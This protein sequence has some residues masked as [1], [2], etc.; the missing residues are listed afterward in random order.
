MGRVQVLELVGLFLLK[1][2]HYFVETMSA[3]VE[4]ALVET[5]K[6]VGED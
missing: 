6:D 2:I 1:E 5:E 4:V 3:F